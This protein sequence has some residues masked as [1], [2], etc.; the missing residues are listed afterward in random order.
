MTSLFPLTSAAPLS[1]PAVYFD[2][3]GTL[4]EDVDYCADPARVRVYA[5][6]PG[7]LAR[8]KERGYVLVMATNQSGIGR[9]YFT[10][11]DFARVQAEC[12][13]QLGPGLLDAC[14]HC[15]EAPA[16]ASLR[17][18]P[19]PGMLLEGARDH[20]L[21]LARSYMVGDNWTDVECGRRAGV[22]ASVLVLTG[23]GPEQAGRCRPDHVAAGLAGAADWILG[24]DASHHG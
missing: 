5:D 3:D 6:A 9:G 10:E 23:K 20:R 19:G 18:K 11:A 2:R 16:G 15:A 1:R 21:D 12:L 7:A 14:Y 8:L 17:R 22:A 24:R 4:M 13:R